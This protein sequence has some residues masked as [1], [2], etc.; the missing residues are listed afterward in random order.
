MTDIRDDW[1]EAER[2]HRAAADGDV[3]LMA[4]LV[5]SGYKVNEFD[6]LSRTPLHYAVDGQHYL[7]ARWLL[8]NGADV[9]I[10]D[11]KMIGETA[12]CF[13]AQGNY[14]EMAELLLQRGGNP[15]IAGWM[16]QTA[17]DRAQRRKDEEGR[18]IAEL[19][20]RHHPS[21]TSPS[22]RK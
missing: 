11:E 7:A 22:C 9:N 12:L 15:D 19:I 1:F 17:R 2:L 14:P 16:Q 8:D 10:N 13:A 6:D 20:E 5:Q 18:K 4:S 21:Q 3:S